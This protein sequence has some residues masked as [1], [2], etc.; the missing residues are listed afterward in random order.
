MHIGAEDSVLANKI[1]HSLAHF[2]I[3]NCILLAKRS[4][5]CPVSLSICVFV[6][7]AVVQ[8]CYL[9]ATFYGVGNTKCF[10][11]LSVYSFGDVYW[12]C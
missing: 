3:R 12:Q 1:L 2:W 4:K 7:S 9:I 6:C 11:Y 8:V 10:S 5:R